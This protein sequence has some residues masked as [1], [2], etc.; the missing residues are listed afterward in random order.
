MQCRLGLG[1]AEP[2][3]FTRWDAVVAIVRRNTCSGVKDVLI[4]FMSESKTNGFKVSKWNF[5]D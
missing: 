2:R 5:V 3:E 4:N 1:W